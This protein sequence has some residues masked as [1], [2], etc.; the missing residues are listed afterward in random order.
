MVLKT[1]NRLHRC[2][3]NHLR[4]RHGHKCTKYKMCLRMMTVISIKQH[5]NNIWSSVHEKLSNVKAAFKK[6]V[7]YKKTCNTWH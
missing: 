7:A 4:P 3:I 6:S 5:L 2:D 1:K